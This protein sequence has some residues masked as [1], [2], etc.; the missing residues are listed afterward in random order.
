MTP[1]ARQ[2]IECLPLAP[3]TQDPLTLVSQR[4]NLTRL[5]RGRS[6]VPPLLQKVLGRLDQIQA[7]PEGETLK[8]TAQLACPPPLPLLRHAVA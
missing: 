5:L 2:Q 3:R 1:E 4:G 7:F 6:G 8:I